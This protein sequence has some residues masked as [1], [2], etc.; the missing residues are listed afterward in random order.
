MP[1]FKKEVNG[2]TVNYQEITTETVVANPTA[3]GT[4]QLQKLQVGNTVYNMPEGETVVAN[5]MA[6]GTEQLQKLQVGNTVYNMPGGGGGGLT[7]TKVTLT[8]LQNMV[9]EV[10][11][12]I[13]NG[14]ETKFY[15]LL[16][17]PIYILFNEYDFGSSAFDSLPLGVFGPDVSGGFGFVI[18]KTYI[19][20]YNNKITIRDLLII[21]GPVSGIELSVI[22]YDHNTGFTTTIEDKTQ[23]LTDN[24]CVIYIYK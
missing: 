16:G 10:Q 21:I 14:D 3:E 22:E 4:E 6:E 2:Q 20:G 8:E 5:P 24:N 9:N 17:T 7:K 12:A 13:A 11:S 19:Y 1:V 23:Y 18:Q 15:E